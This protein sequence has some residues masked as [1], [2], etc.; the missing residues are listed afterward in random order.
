MA[1]KNILSTAE[2]LA[3][4]SKTPLGS[5]TELT[6]GDAQALSRVGI[7]VTN[8]GNETN[9]YVDALAKES[10]ESQSWWDNIFGTIDNVANSFKTGFAS[11]FEGIVDFGVTLAGGIGSAFGA[12]SKWAEDFV[13]VDMA[14]NLANFTE[15]FAN[16]TAWGIGKTIYNIATY[17]D[18]YWQDLG[19]AWSTLGLGQWGGISDEEYKEWQEK[20]AFGHDVLEENTGWFGEGVLALSEGAGQLLAM[21]VTMGIGGAAGLGTK[22]AQGV[23]LAASSLGAA[24]KGSEQALEEGASIGQATLYGLLTGAVEAGTELLG[25]IGTDVASGVVGKAILKN[26]A[27]KKV[28]STLGGKMLAGFLSEG[29]EEVLADV[30]NPLLKKISYD[31]E[32]DLGGEYSSGEF[33]AGLAQSFVVGGLLGGIGEGMQ[34]YKL[35]KTTINGKKVGQKGAI[36]YSEFADAKDDLTK[37]AKKLNKTFSQLAE[38]GEIDIAEKTNIDKAVEIVKNSET[39]SDVQKKSL[40]NAL[41]RAYEANKKYMTAQ[42]TLLSE[43]ESQGITG[44]DLQ[45]EYN[46]KV[47]EKA[48][49]VGEELNI[50]VE[51]IG[52]VAETVKSNVE[53]MK[54]I[55]AGNVGSFYDGDGKVIIVGENAVAETTSL[56]SLELLK[57][58]NGAIYADAMVVADQLVTADETFASEVDKYARIYQTQNG[59]SVDEATKLA[60]QT[61]MANRLAA[62]FKGKPGA[63]Q[64]VDNI[65]K[66]VDSMQN[67]LTSIES[68]TESEIIDGEPMLP[69]ETYNPM[70]VFNNETTALVRTMDEPPL[71]KKIR[72]GKSAIKTTATWL[73]NISYQTETLAVKMSN[74]A[75]AIEKAFR[76]LGNLSQREAMQKTEE[77]RIAS[78]VASDVYANGFSIINEKQQVE[79]TTKG[80]YNGKDGI[81]DI[82]EKHFAGDLRGKSRVEA[83]TNGMK[84]FNEALALYVEMDR[85]NASMGTDLVTLEDIDNL[86]KREPE[87][88]KTVFGKWLETRTM[89]SDLLVKI[90]DHFPL[91]FEAIQKGV[92]L[93]EA[94]VNELTHKTATERSITLEGEALDTFNEVS[95]YLRLLN[96]QDI[97]TRLAEIDAEFPFF[98][99]MREEV[100]KYNRELLRMQY[101]GGYL[102]K[103]AYEWMQRNYS[104]YVP[105]YREMIMNA[106]ANVSMS[107]QSS[108]LKAAKGSDLVI[109]DIFDSMQMQTT[110]IH[111]KVAINELIKDLANTSKNYGQLNEYVVSEEIT[112][113]NLPR[114][115][116]SSM[117]YYLTRPALDGNTITYYEGG[118]SHSYLVNNNVMEGLQSLSGVY[119]DTLLSIPGMKFIAKAQKL[120]KN[121]LTTYNP[122]FGLRN[123]IRDLWD[124]SF[125]SPTGMTSVLRNLPKAYKSIITN[126]IEYQ[127]F[128]A[129]GG[130]GTS[131]MTST[132]IYTDKPKRSDKLEYVIKPWKAIARVNEIIEVATRYAQYLATTNQ[133][134]KERAKG[135]NQMSNRQIATRGVYEAHEITLNF[136]RSGTIGRQ[137]N[138]SFGLFLNANIQ[139]FTKMM[140]VFKSPKTAK[141]WAELI[142]KC[143]IMGIS[144]QLL[145]E[146]LYFDDEDYQSLSQSIKNNYYLIKVGDQFIRIPKGRVISAFN[147]IVSGA[148]AG[149]KGDKGAMDEAFNYALFEANSPIPGQKLL[150]WGF[151][152][153]MDDAY[154]NR[155]WYGGEIVSSKWDGTRPTEQYEKDTSYISRWIGKV[156]G[157]SPLVVEYILDQYTG[158]IGDIL[159]PLTSDEASGYKLMRIVKD[160]YLI[161]P[162][163]KSKYSKDF[164]DYKEQVTYDKTDGDAIAS[165]QVAYMNKAQSEIQALQKEIKAIEADTSKAAKDIAGETKTI[166][167]MIN[168]AYKAAVENA[169]AIGEALKG[170]TITEENAAEVQRE[171]YREVL[172]AEASLRMYNKNVY[173]K[174]QCYYKAGV[175]YDDFYVYYFNTRNFATKDEAERYVAGLRISPQLKNLIYRLAGWN[176]GKD[177][178][179]VL[180]RWLKNKGL[181]DEEIDMIL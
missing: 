133:L 180:M 146:L 81:V 56:N 21:Y 55:E 16:F 87:K 25:G 58:A 27:L 6:F 109:K 129:N 38:V 5:T 150:S 123:A 128:V 66:V 170:Y 97:N 54:D 26:P 98:Q 52:A 47:D 44:E 17:G 41:N 76:K 110:K 164:Y 78:S 50:D 121:L 89:P 37:R 49:A 22:A 48:K 29:L 84:A 105:T 61:A 64:K 136:S 169:Q 155:T 167:I 162:V 137:I 45:S 102:T 108:T 62:F 134:Y 94:T 174:A 176:L 11:M 115:T 90:N 95:K 178:I 24:G 96:A 80:I 148:F 60:K 82:L 122:F 92:A 9:E 153:A 70:E 131:I 130:I 143:L 156:T 36:A 161:D 145:N 111:Q 116:D 4:M 20:Y 51:N 165:I 19:R 171:V 142:L 163:E 2:F 118:V 68:T 160:Q 14:G 8:Y 154:K 18:E 168:A 93:D 181:T 7:D 35:G 119:R 32:M 23:A 158:I 40:D 39:L 75:A 79:R 65:R 91:L 104:H 99:E 1:K 12:D 107:M 126:D 83:I 10:Q 85:L 69:A 73:D 117:T 147:A 114:S 127:T 113:D 74:S 100:W 149:A 72:V 30:S 28:T 86:S 177:K 157:Q 112:G 179:E 132:E 31:Y 34:Y 144:T 13:R 63:L 42:D 46:K 173:A 151:F 172:G 77:V 3:K 106:S 15:T 140:R 33:W 159:L 175:S 124:A 88:R 166:Q 103:E 101:E 139:G 125:Y 43:L 138:N 57:T 120:V 67:S 141:E 135:L 59:L 53:I 71:Q 152:Q